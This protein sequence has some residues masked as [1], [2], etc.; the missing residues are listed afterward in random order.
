MDFKARI[1]LWARH[2]WVRYRRVIIIGFVVWFIVFV[3]NQMVKNRPILNVLDNTFN[4]DF[5]VITDD[6]VPSGYQT[7]I[8]KVMDDYINYCNNKNYDEA[9]ALLTD[10]CKSY[11]YSNRIGE[12][13]TYVDTLFKTP[14]I[15]H[16]QN[17]SNTDNYY[18]Y[19]VTIMDD[20]GATGTTGNYDTHIE[21]FT[22]VRQK[23]GKFKVSTNDFIRTVKLDKQQEDE[24][25]IVKVQS[26]NQSYN[27]IEYI[28]TIINR[29]DKYLVLAD[30]TLGMEI[31][32]NLNGEK[33]SATNL[34]NAEVV[35]QPGQSDVYSLIFDK[36]FDDN[37]PP[38]ELNFNSVR[39]LEKYES[40]VDDTVSIADKYYSF[41]FIF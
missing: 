35:I 15:Y 21:K 16:Y 7:Q 6:E 39:L 31:T 37:K 12:F 4:P 28:V 10:D 14:K 41:N 1:S 24:N 19:D 3:I 38:R 13:K 22:F 33:R 26:Y 2:I 18:I 5:S 29:T 23:D 36:Y 11:L 20:I 25:I 27:K 34:S 30:G 40:Y 9:Y 8:K 32:L 17:F